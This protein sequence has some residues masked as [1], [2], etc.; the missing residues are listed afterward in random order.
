MKQLQG[1]SRSLLNSR[2]QIP[3]PRVF[4]YINTVD[5]GKMQNAAHRIDL[6]NVEVHRFNMLQIHP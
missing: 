1:W 4:V 2:S 6:K 5:R 3:Y